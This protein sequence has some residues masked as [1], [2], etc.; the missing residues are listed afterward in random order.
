MGIEIG[1]QTGPRRG[2]AIDI[3]IVTLQSLPWLW[4][5]QGVLEMIQNPKI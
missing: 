3:V 1:K 5:L 4:R 2:T